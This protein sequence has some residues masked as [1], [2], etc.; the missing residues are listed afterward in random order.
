MT[1]RNVASQCAS[2]RLVF[3]AANQAVVA[4]LCGA[5]VVMVAKVDRDLF[6]EGTLRNFRSF[7]IDTKHIRLVD[8]TLTEVALR[9]YSRRLSTLTLG[10]IAY[11][12]P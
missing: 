4:R 3:L 7:V 6:G 2:S 12:G 8:D 11:A 10:L 5:E 1:T 9:A